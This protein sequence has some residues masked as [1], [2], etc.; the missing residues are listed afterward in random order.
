DPL[1]LVLGMLRSSFRSLSLESR[2]YP[3]HPPRKRPLLAILALVAVLAGCGGGGGG[4]KT[5]EAASGTRVT[6]DGF[7]FSA[8]PSWHASHASTSVTVR[9]SG[10]GPT[11]TSVTR[12]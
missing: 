7:S 11:L 1:S 9:P 2:V 3:R 5:T 4:A 6:G 8:P 10:E 12:L